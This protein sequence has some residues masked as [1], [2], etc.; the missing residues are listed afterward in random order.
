MVTLS[1]VSTD[2]GQRDDVEKLAMEE[3]VKRWEVE[4]RSA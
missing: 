3:L 1:R 4:A 2:L